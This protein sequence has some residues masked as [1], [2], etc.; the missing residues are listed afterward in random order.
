L[1]SQLQQQNDSSTKSCG[2]MSTESR[3]VLGE[4]F[5]EVKAM[6]CAPTRPLEFQTLI[7]ITDTD[8]CEL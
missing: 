5:T 1:S 7:Q 2:F 8:Q 3:T 6:S 4:V